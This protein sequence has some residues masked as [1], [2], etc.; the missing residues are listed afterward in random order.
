LLPAL[1]I[2]ACIATAGIT[3]QAA[4]FGHASADSLVATQ[5]VRQLVRYRIMRGTE[6][7][8]GRRTAAT[9]LQGAFRAPGGRRLAHGELVLLGNGER[10]YDLGFGVRRLSPTGRSLGANRVDRI[11]F[12]LAGCPSYLGSHVGDDLVRGRP[13]EA[14]LERSDGTA[15]AAIVVGSRSA[16]LR[17]DVSRGTHKPLALSLG[18]GRFRGSSDL[19]PGGG[20]AAIRAVQRAFDLSTRHRHA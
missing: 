3:V 1:A 9:C 19:S 7:L 13:V 20:P 12:V 17:L 14:F 4:A 11:R 10:L 8:G 18:E 5:A 16:T 15:A 2:P 6:S